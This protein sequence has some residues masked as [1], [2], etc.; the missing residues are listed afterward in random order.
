MTD[1]DVLLEPVFQVAIE[2]HLAER[3]A[4]GADPNWLGQQL[5]QV[6]GV[7]EPPTSDVAATVLALLADMQWADDRTH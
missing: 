4:A 1:T 6:A 3:Q 2:Q 7:P 5:R